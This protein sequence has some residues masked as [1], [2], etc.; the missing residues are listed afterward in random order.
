MRINICLIS[1]FLCFQVVKGQ[2]GAILDKS[3]TIHAVDLS[4]RSILDEISVDLG[5][6]FGYSES[7]IDVLRKVSIAKKNTSLRTVLRTLFPSKH[8]LFKVLE[9]KVLIYVKDTDAKPLRFTLNGYI[10]EK[11]SQEYLSN[12]SLYIPA[13]SVGCRTNSY[14]FYSLTIPEGSYELWISFVGY[15][16]ALYTIELQHSKIQNFELEFNAEQLDEVVIS[17]V[18]KGNKNDATQMSK[19]E[20]GAK[21][22]NS[23]PVLL[24]E[25][26]ALKTL[27]LFPG[28]SSITEGAAGI[29]V[30][31]GSADQNLIL[32]DEAPVYNS[33]HLFG[34]FSIFN[35]DAVQNIELFKG[36]FPA[37]F[38]GRLSSVIQIQTKDGNKSKWG[39]RVNIGTV[40]SSFLL[41]GPLKKEK[42]SFVLTGRRTYLDAFIRPF[43]DKNEDYVFLFSDLNFKIH[44]IFSEKDKLIWSN[45]FGEDKIISEPGTTGVGNFVIKWGNITSTLRWNHEFSNRLFSNT[46][47]IFSKY[48]FSAKTDFLPKEISH[49]SGVIDYAAKV[50]FNYYPKPSHNVQAGFSSTFHDF[51]PFRFSENFNLDL[52]QEREQRLKSLESAVYLEDDWRINNQINIRP[53]IRVSHFKQGPYTFLRP[54]LRFGLAWKRAKGLRYKFSF[55]RMNQYIHLLSHSGTSLPTDLWVSTGRTLKPQL[56]DLWTIGLLKKFL[57]NSFTLS[58]ESYYKRMHEVLA[59]KNNYSFFDTVVSK[60]S[61]YFWEND[62]AAGDGWAYGIE[63]LLRK[64]KGKFQGWLGYTFSRSQRQFDEVNNGLKFDAKGDRRHSLKLAAT[65]RPSKKFLWSANWLLASGE[66]FTLSD[67]IG[68]SNTNVF[69]MASTVRNEVNFAQQT[70]NFKVSP[71]H[72]LDVGFQ[73]LKTTKRNRERTWTFSVY[74][75]YAKKNPFSFDIVNQSSL[76]Q[77][78]ILMVIP[79]VLYSYKF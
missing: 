51:V 35:A 17:G 26:D 79:S 38:G 59:F 61:Q 24:G 32:I 19:L 27:Q 48:Q 12:V 11:G 15:Q 7:T 50:D 1:F 53:G 64:H 74:N 65:Y 18:A 14:G 20:I 40:S 44:H 78:S 13:L 47:L 4:I 55:A 69:P 60:S 3:T 2:E 43:L 66:N 36:G 34:A 58:V 22:I 6:Q 54:E 10:K 71:Y 45:Y 42:T 72:R 29:Q 49:D 70:N 30:R 31:G 52:D 21:E 28:V 63:V 68:L 25:R 37:K 76:E 33:R 8:Y 73:Y 39:G 56:S 5:I 62:L 67:R 23:T 16:D 75:V 77:L 46:S 41:E 9:N 57:K